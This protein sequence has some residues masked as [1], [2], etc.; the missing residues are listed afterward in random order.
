[1]KK[2]NIKYFVS[3]IIVC[4]IIAAGVYFLTKSPR[5]DALFRIRL[6]SGKSPASTK[7]YFKPFKITA[8]GSTLSVKT[9]GKRLAFEGFPIKKRLITGKTFPINIRPNREGKYMIDFF[10]LHR[11]LKT[12]GCKGYLRHLR[13]NGKKEI[14]RIKLKANGK[15]ER[16]RIPL[17]LEKND[18]ISFD[19]EGAFQGFI[20]NP[21]FYEIE[22]KKEKNFVFVILAD[23]LRWDRIGAL[24]PAKK[25]SPRIDEFCKDSVL[26]SRCYSTSSWTLP[27]HAS[28]FSGL[29]SHRHGMNRI[30]MVLDSKNL[31]S[32]LQKKFVTYSVN[33]NHFLANHFGF[34]RA[35]DYHLEFLKEFNSPTA[36]KRL[37]ETAKK[38]V[39]KEKSGSAFF[40]LHTYQVHNIYT[41]EKELAREYYNS[42]FNIF[43]FSPLDFIESGKDLF[44]KASPKEKEEIEKIYD[45][46]VYTF[47]FRFGEFISFLK[48]EGIY[49]N[50]TIIFL[51]DH[52]EEFMDH[53]AWEHS[54]GLYDE[55]IK[56]PLI[57]K[58]PGHRHAGKKIDALTSIVD[59]MP[60]LLD[61]YEIESETPLDIDGF[62]LLKTMNGE[63]DKE[64]VLLAYLAP[65]AIRKGVPEK[66]ALLTGN[67][68]FIFNRRMKGSDLKIFTTP[69]PELV[70][71]MFDMFKDPLERVNI[72]KKYQ[73]RVAQFMKF[74]KRLKFKQGKKGDLKDVKDD[75]KSIGYI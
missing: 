28:L 59:I 73:K 63:Y 18:T 16:Y 12:G 20:S 36:A 35:F 49:K 8:A 34:S 43:E 37:F 74:I 10:F 67:L 7:I 19:I 30:S 54:H 31:V 13:N 14:R 11:R 70:N 39:R 29:F 22:T 32:E 40:F 65:Y 71:E 38:L 62:S 2:L 45:A 55:Q 44:K 53:G 21:V 1:M 66:S 47:D 64:R 5:S 6:T 56:I 25:C 26:F 60:T 33:G 23:T 4:F 57:V 42:D 51:S 24:N 72:I 69:P 50:S 41:P 17:R 52:G 61:L 9:K 48:K 58:F 3:I 75:L 15:I 68:K 46:G 27:A